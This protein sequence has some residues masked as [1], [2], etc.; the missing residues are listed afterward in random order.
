LSIQNINFIKKF[1]NYDHQCLN[2]PSCQSAENSKKSP[3]LSA[4]R[5]KPS[6]FDY[7]QYA[8]FRSIEGF[9]HFTP[10]KIV[11]R[12]GTMLGAICWIILRDRRETVT[13]NCRI[14]YEYK[15]DSLEIRR[16]VKSIFSFAGANLLGGIKTATMKDQKLREQITILGI[17]EVNDHLSKSNNGVIFALAHMGNWEL[18]AH[19]QKILRIDRPCA[20]F[21]RPL[22]NPLLNQL[23]SKRRRQSGTDLFSN[24]DGFSRA[25][26]HLRNGGVLGILADQ[27]AGR[28]GV[29]IPFFGRNTSCTPLIEILHRRTKASIFHVAVCRTAPAHWKIEIRQHT[30][31][32]QGHTSSIM[33]GIEQSIRRSP[34]D[35]F[36]FHNRWKM[37]RLRPFHQKQHSSIFLTPKQTKPWQVVIVTTKNPEICA[38]SMPA[39]ELLIQSEAQFH[40]FILGIPTDFEAHNATWITPSSEDNSTHFLRKLDKNQ[41]CPIDLILFFTEPHDQFEAMNK[42]PIP[43]AAGFSNEATKLLSNRIPLPL[44]KMDEPATWFHFIQALGAKVP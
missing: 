38:A 36:W 42:S 6:F 41:S 27:H 33:H 39:I 19:L 32:Q 28:A 17:E 2:V 9:L 16:L 43:M 10:A 14:A 1:L 22:N 3:I 18:L 5:T 23:I 7:L 34:A 12:I 8:L 20:A 4:I 25:T 30:H 15:L 26:T 31:D 35:G 44:T 29:I 37:Q 24:K 21:Y 13:R 40:F 11:D